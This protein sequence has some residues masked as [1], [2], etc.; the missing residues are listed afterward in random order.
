MVSVDWLK[1]FFENRKQYVNFPGHSSSV[2]TLPQGST[3]GLSLFLLHTNDLKSVFSKSFVHHFADKMCL[4]MLINEVLSWNK[5][6]DDICTKLAKASGILL[7][8]PQFVPK[9]H[10]FQYISPFFTLMLFMVVWFGPT[11]TNVI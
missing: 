11:Q 3:L 6:I 2:K 4:G 7:N 5:Q 8:L 10:A 9:K 1:L